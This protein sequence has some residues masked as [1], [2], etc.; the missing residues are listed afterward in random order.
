[1]LNTMKTEIYTEMGLLYL[2]SDTLW[3]K[4][5]KALH[6]LLLVMFWAPVIFLIKY[7]NRRPFSRS[8]EKD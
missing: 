7:T 4:A 1:M 2:E 5:K 3:Q 8:L 6:R